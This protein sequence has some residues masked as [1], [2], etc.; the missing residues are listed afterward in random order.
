MPTLETYIKLIQ[1]FLPPSLFTEGLTN[2]LKKVKDEWPQLHD[3]NKFYSTSM[4]QTVFY[5]GDAVQDILFPVIQPGTDEY[6]TKYYPG[7][8]LS[9]TCDVDLQN[10]R[11]RHENFVVFA[12]V[13]PLSAYLEDLE[14]AGISADS[15]QSFQSDLKFQ[16]IT[17]LFYLPTLTLNG[18]ELMAESFIRFDHVT[19]LQRRDFHSKWD[20]DFYPVGDRLCTLSDA[21]FYLFLFKLSVHF[22]RFS[23]EFPRT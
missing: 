10:A 2:T 8:V 19:H 12:A 16:R 22:C 5:Q 3:P 1:Q 17:D 20:K 23:P 21:A 7:V 9:N 14:S 4:D 6:E 13:Y 15:I 18:Q 11:K